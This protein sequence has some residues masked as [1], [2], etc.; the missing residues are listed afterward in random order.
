LTVHTA[1]E[2]KQAEH[3]A[4]ERALADFEARGG[5]IERLPNGV[6][7]HNAGELRPLGELIAEASRAR[8]AARDDK[9]RPEHGQRIPNPKRLSTAPKPRARPEIPPALAH[10]LKVLQPGDTATALAAR[11]G[12]GHQAALQ[13]LFR[14]EDKGLVTRNTV[15]RRHVEWSRCP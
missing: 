13:L 14:L 12:K 8:Q 3:E 15:T 11:L 10:V 2:L 6:M 4:M 5:K 9:A 1:T 7:K